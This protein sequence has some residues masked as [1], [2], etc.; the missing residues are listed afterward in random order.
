MTAD[1]D[2]QPKTIPRDA[3]QELTQNLV[4][5]HWPLVIAV[6]GPA[7]SGKSTVA[8]AV[9]RELGYLLVDTG[10][11]Y[12]ATTLLAIQ[13]AMITPE[14]LHEGQLAALA[15]TAI[16]D[17]Q[18]PPRHD[19]RDYILL[20]NG[21]DVSDAVR[22]K[23]VEGLVSLVASL[24]EVRAVMN[25]KQRALAARGAV[26]MVGRDIGTKV[27]PDAPLK[28]YLDAT[29]E[30]RAQRRYEQYQAL[31]RLADYDELLQ[32]I[33]AR[34]A[35]DTTRAVDPL[36]QAADAVYLDTSAL[37]IEAVILAMKA[38]IAGER[39]IAPGDIIRL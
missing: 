19:P 5:R 25:E 16:M 21:E 4:R 10:A 31:G 17:L 35:M 2:Q 14:S 36:R 18:I 1:H 8:A 37:S 33:R 12:R 32:N 27:L 26:I 38:L 20:L 29:P 7:G 9:A 23:D 3:A 15:R 39:G 24:P 6:D 34:D 11:F 13:H 28:V 30:V 22:A